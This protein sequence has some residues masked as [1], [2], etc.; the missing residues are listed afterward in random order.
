MPQESAHEPDERLHTVIAEYLQ[1]AEAGQPPDRT[2]LLARYPDLAEGLREFFAGHDRVRQAVAT[3]HAAPPTPP[4]G[5]ATVGADEPTA[6]P[7]P[8]GAPGTRFAD[9]ELLGEIARGGMGVVFRARQV[10]LNRVVALKMILA[11]QF[12]ADADVQRFRAEAEA[13]AALD[14]PHIVPIYEVGEHEGQ[15]YF[16]M[17]LVEGGSLQAHGLQPAGL[18]GRQREAA[19]L[20]AAVARAVHYAHQRGILHRDLK[21]ANILLDREGQPHVTD[22]GLAKK[23]EGGSDVTRS[24]AVVGTPSYMA[25]EQARGEKVLSTAADV[26]SLGAVLYE[27]L[28]GRPPL[29][30][31]S[32]LD[33]LMQ[34][35]DREPER[36]RRL[37]PALD[38]DLETI[39][40]K[41][42][43]KDPQRR[44]ASAEE[45]A[46][47]L[48]RW[49]AGETI[50]ARPSTRWERTVKW[51]RRRPA[52]SALI[53][54][55]ALSLVALLA[56]AGFLWH[57]AELRA[58]AVQDLAQAHLQIRAAEAEAEA[59]TQFALVM[60]RVARE[61]LK[62]VKRLE[63]TAREAKAKAIA[64]DAHAQ[65]TVYAADMQL[66]HAAWQTGNVPRLVGLLK[67]HRPL[68]GQS[69]PRGFE[70][71]YLHRL[72]HGDR[73]TLQWLPDE[74]RKG[75][76][77]NPDNF[78]VLALSRDGKMLATVSP[79]AP[80]RLWDRATGKPLRTLA[81]P[82]GPVVA[83]TFAAG[84]KELLLVVTRPGGKGRA[85]HD[86]KQ[87]QAVVEGKAKPSLRPLTDTLAVQRLPVDGGPPA[88]P[89]PLD[90][91]RLP[92]AVSFFH[93]GL[94]GSMA[95][96]AAASFPVRG[97]FLTPTALALAPDGKTLAIAAVYI[98]QPRTAKHNKP[99]GAVVLWDLAAG[100][101]R[102]VFTEHQTIITTLAFSP[103]GKYLASGS[104]DRTVH[105]RDGA[106]GENRAGFLRFDGLVM[107]LTFSPDGKTLA[108]ACA[109][110]TAELWDGASRK[111][112]HKLKGH[113]NGLSSLAFTPD[114]K[115]LA[116]GSGDGTVKFWD[117]FRNQ[118]P[119]ARFSNSGSV[120]A[121]AF[122]AD[123]RTLAAID[124][125]GAFRVWDVRTWQ[126]H[127]STRLTLELPLITCAAVSRDGRTVAASGAS[128]TVELL[129]GTTGARRKVLQ[130]PTKTGLVY[131]LAFAPDGKI[132]AAGSG[133]LHKEGKVRLWDPA[134]GKELHTFGG[135]A[136]HVAGLAFSPDGKL[137]AATGRDGTVKVWEARAGKELF[138][139]RAK[140][141]VPC[142][143]FSP[144]GR[145]LAWASGETVTVREMPGGKE[146]LTIQGYGHRVLEMAFSPDGTRLATVGGGVMTGR[147][148]SVKL[149]DLRTGQ[150]VLSLSGASDAVTALAFSPDGKR[151]AAAFAEEQTINPFREVQAEVH[152]WDATPVGERP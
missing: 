18:P 15:H 63:E 10:S 83:L 146:V 57:N 76:A 123:A 109:D 113:L 105:L 78:P 22:F 16:S 37:N 79:V 59:S 93:A 49:L 66:A 41:C 110:G 150:E 3:L 87:F 38:A 90:P 147:G 125:G 100:R 28:T 64:I 56:L 48:E 55:S 25:P 19:R 62:E 95:A 29:R 120:H 129:D 24:G 116:T 13:A 96:M 81:A 141:E 72:A 103:D 126:E 1:A 119:A 152:V 11:G 140:G 5:A 94:Q 14:H 124:Q 53:A 148:V 139:A 132:L 131:A 20:L 8:C 47:D 80:V 115:E 31:D 92:A 130:G 136:A 135:F 54:V 43:D 23:V 142:L 7:E 75:P 30:G 26:Y 91:A 117:P 121:L 88:A 143:A 70:W 39:C 35:L 98:P 97:A 114:G 89:E 77:D 67:R 46:R 151:L 21:P 68:P 112:G 107:A 138:S 127:A 9:Y 128:D 71:H 27:L 45:L 82:A 73:L 44:Y 36:P 84:D 4:G 74:L 12:A 6:R 101:D 108:V 133:L 99:S 122:S 2:A 86:R 134:T 32:P 51:A 58:E 61:K 111:G 85:G 106:T 118:G 65:R 137:L 52:A 17:K 40:L 60:S 50:Q 34:V 42:L 104:L 145:H 33:T 149:W 144:D 69:D 102:A